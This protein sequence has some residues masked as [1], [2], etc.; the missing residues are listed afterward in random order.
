VIG[1]VPCHLL[2]RCFPDDRVYSEKEV[3]Q[4]LALYH[5][6]VAALRRHLVDAGL[7]TRQGGDYRRA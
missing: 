3:N 5:P 4:L 6:D 1:S 2:E 7:M